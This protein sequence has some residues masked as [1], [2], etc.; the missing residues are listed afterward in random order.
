MGR[1]VLKMGFVLCVKCTGGLAA[2]RFQV[3][4]P[5]P[6]V[7]MQ[8]KVPS[9]LGKHLSAR[10]KSYWAP[11]WLPWGLLCWTSSQQDA[12]IHHVQGRWST[13]WTKT[14]QDLPSMGQAPP[15]TSSATEGA[16]GERRGSW[17]PGQDHHTH[18]R[19]VILS[20]KKQAVWLP[21]WP[22]GWD[23]TF[24]CRGCGFNPWWG[25]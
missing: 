21:W 2:P 12:L 25:S 3:E 4:H 18:S 22:S 1:G 20:F 23:F 13:C 11:T 8:E 9:L 14:A 17:A 16:W 19:H 15:A 5:Q 10:K 6:T 7:G 24:Q